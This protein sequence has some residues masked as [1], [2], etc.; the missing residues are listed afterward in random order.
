MA[1]LPLYFLQW[2]I[3]AASAVTTSKPA[4]NESHLNI[5]SVKQL[6]I[7]T[8]T[9]T[10]MKSPQ[11]D[12]LSYP[13]KTTGST[14]PGCV[15][16]AIAPALLAYPCEVKTITRT[17]IEITTYYVDG[18]PTVSTL[19]VPPKNCT[20]A[21]ILGNPSLMA[22]ATWSWRGIIL[23]Y[24]TTYFAYDFFQAGTWKTCG[25]S[26]NETGF[27]LDATVLHEGQRATVYPASEA[28]SMYM[29]VPSPVAEYV[30]ADPNLSTALD[31][32]TCTARIPIVQECN[33][34][35]SSGKSEPGMQI[36]S[37]V[38]QSFSP[39]MRGFPEPSSSF[40]LRL[41]SFLATDASPK[42]TVTDSAEQGYAV[43]DVTFH[44]TTDVLTSS[45]SQPTTTT[46]TANLR[47][48][49]NYIQDLFPNLKRDR[50][51]KHHH[52]FREIKVC[53]ALSHISY[54]SSQRV[55]QR[56]CDFLSRPN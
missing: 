49:F 36:G 48:Q 8:D 29:T 10:P 44:V 21:S 17:F 25:C 24:P 45:S 55:Q 19:T 11:L 53:V 28:Q 18:P 7:P 46:P 3:W 38:S 37:G 15:F 20:E 22:P 42:S 31:I 14:T 34:Y 16:E 43:E 5:N 23:T 30:M 35:T 40:L 12:C 47:V 32:R 54:D 27:T 52:Y 2:Y 51:W 50:H 41:P 56:H 39:G 4:F 1:V 9:T 26:S 13:T 6:P 33:I